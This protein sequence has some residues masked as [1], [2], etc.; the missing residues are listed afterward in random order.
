MESRNLAT[1]QEMVRSGEYLIPTMNGELRLEKPPLPTWIAA[2]IEHIIPGSLVAQRCAAGIMATVMVFFLYFITSRLTRNRN[3]GFL[4]SLILASCFSVVLLGR[5]ASWDI[6]CHSFMLGAIYFFILAFEEE[7]SQWKNFILTGIFLGLSFLSKGPVS[8]YA[9]LLP[10]LISFI[11]VYKPGIKNKVAPLIVMVLIC[12]VISCWWTAYIYIFHQE[13]LIN[14]VKKESSSWLNHSVRPW[15]YYWKFPAEAG[16]WAL[17]LIT[18]I[19]YFFVSKRRENKREFRFFFVWLAASLI[20][21]SLIPEKKARYLLPI[22]IPGSGVIAFY[23]Y[24]C[25]K[26]LNKHGEKLIFRINAMLIT[27]ILAAIPFIMYSMFYKEGIISLTIL[28]LSVVFSW[29]LCVYI[30]KCLFHKS[31]VQVLGTF[32]GIIVCMVMIEAFCL[33]PIGHM[34]INEER[35]SIRMLRT[36]EEV[37]DLPF[38]YNKEETLRMELVYEANQTIVPIDVTDSTFIYKNAPFVFISGQPITDVFA[39]MNIEV[40]SIDTF[41]NNWQRPNQRHYN[42]GLVREV[43]IIKTK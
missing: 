35:H 4:A 42:L 37:A 18:S 1:A 22:L 13:M 21:L 26:G 11:F 17:F 33:I 43:A 2:G 20:L 10:F 29:G 23:I 24:R 12:V 28:I 25:F 30:M 14:V 15:Y 6:Y 27:L 36:N 40:D 7:G 32:G 39:G 3:V 19:I 16:V 5:T 9:L 41:D 31:G 38:F 34:F 8:F